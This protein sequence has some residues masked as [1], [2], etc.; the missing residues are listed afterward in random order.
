MS[1]PHLNSL[2]NNVNQ[3]SPTV[4][5]THQA[6]QH[7]QR[8]TTSSLDHHTQTTHTSNRKR[9][10]TNFNPP[11]PSDIPGDITSPNT[12]Q[13]TYTIEIPY[14]SKRT[15]SSHPNP[16]TSAT[17][18]QHTPTNNP[19]RK[20]TPKQNRHKHLHQPDTCPQIKHTT[21]HPPPPTIPLQQE[22]HHSNA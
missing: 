19:S 17:S 15:K 2:E 12:Q 9:P 20:R 22:H 11:L 14:A 6:P 7:T 18:K 16:P 8:T 4:Y 21:T 10:R 1:G 3:Y 5:E 13:A